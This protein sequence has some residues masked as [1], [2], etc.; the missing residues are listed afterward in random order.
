MNAKM[1]TPREGLWFDPRTKFLLMLLGV[2]AAATAPNLRYELGLVALIALFAWACGEKRLAL[3]GAAGYG[4]F[5]GLTVVV[6]AGASV[7]VQAILL[8]FLGLVHKV[9]P[10]GFLGGVI[11]STTRISE[12]LSAMSK[13]RVPKALALPLAIMLRYLPTIQEDWHFI[14]DAMRLRDVKPTIGGLLS[15]P[16]MTLSCVYVPLLLAASKA[17]DELSIAAVTRGIENPA[18]RSTLRD[19]RL[20]MADGIA[21]AGFVAYLIAGRFL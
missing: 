16:A 2:L 6:T 4:F 5:Y 19:I 9:Y 14:Q 7:S 1:S 15:H 17:A 3:A 11:I 12:G 13:L 8:A 21:L 18:P 10:A 20:G